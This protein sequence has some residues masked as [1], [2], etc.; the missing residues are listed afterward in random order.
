MQ[1]TS[2]P[3]DAE[4]PLLPGQQSVADIV[5]APS[6]AEATLKSKYGDAA[7]YMPDYVRRFKAF[8]LITVIIC[9]FSYSMR[10]M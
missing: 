7:I 3:A 4:G 9:R 5:T 6:S 1:D 10:R 2:A 8:V